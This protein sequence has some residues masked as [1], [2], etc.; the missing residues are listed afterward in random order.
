MEFVIKKTEYVNKTFRI[1][2]ELNDRLSEIAQAENV[3]VNELVVQ[4]CNFAISNM[5][6]SQNSENN[7]PIQNI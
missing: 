3:S 7:D 5:K 4:C 1:T 6:E 2:K